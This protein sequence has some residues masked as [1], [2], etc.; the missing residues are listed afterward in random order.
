[1]QMIIRKATEN[2]YQ[3][4]GNLI[5][6]ELGYSD[7]DSDKLYSRLNSMSK[8]DLYETFVAVSGETV[9]GFIGICRIIAY[10]F[11]GDYFRIIALAVSENHQN[12]GVGTSLLKHVESFA[13]WNDVRS[14]SLNS[15]LQ[16]IAA[17]EFYKRN[18]Y[19]NKSFGF[20]KT[21]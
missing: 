19:S 4:I 15:G 3:V 9:V 11:D 6:N 14:I 20:E 21:L 12:K 13:L 16:R 5:K 8:D 10:E 1:M 18:G 2:D 17:H 7:I